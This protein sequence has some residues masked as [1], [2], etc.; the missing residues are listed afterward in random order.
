EQPAHRLCA[1]GLPFAVPRTA[2]QEC[3]RLDPQQ[4]GGHLQVVRR[5]AQA[6]VADHAQELIGD[7]R[8]REVGDVELVL[9]DEMQQQIERARELLEL[10]D[11]AGL[12]HGAGGGRQRRHEPAPATIRNPPT[13]ASPSCISRSA[14]QR[15]SVI[16]PGASQLMSR[17]GMNPSMYSCRYFSPAP[18]GS[19]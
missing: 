3:L 18:G 8:D 1:R 7:L 12:V 17:I 4:T 15:K 2:G 9:A 11:E 5:L 19:R 10:D 16:T 14:G 6:Q 13:T